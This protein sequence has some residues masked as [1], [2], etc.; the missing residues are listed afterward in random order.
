MKL[1]SPISFFFFFFLIQQ[2]WIQHHKWIWFTFFIFCSTI[3]VNMNLTDEANLARVL[4]S[5]GCRENKLGESTKAE[6]LL[7]I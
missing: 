3:A 2:Q 1:Q 6:D 5:L 4:R 7:P